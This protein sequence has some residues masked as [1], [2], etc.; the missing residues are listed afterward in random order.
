ML[1]YVRLMLLIQL[2]VA[3]VLAELTKLYVVLTS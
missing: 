1:E 3:D 2:C